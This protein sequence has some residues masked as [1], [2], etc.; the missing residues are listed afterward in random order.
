MEEELKENVP[1]ISFFLI[2]LIASTAFYGFQFVHIICMPCLMHIDNLKVEKDNA[3]D[4]MDVCEEAM[5][6][7]KVHFYLQLLNFLE[8]QIATTEEP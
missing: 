1:D 3:C 8:N 7:A 4:K 6:T 5:K 2:K